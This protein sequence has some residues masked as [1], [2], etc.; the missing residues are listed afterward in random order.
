[1]KFV[2]NQK[3]L[4]VINSEDIGLF[5][6][7]FKKTQAHHSIAEG[8]G[9]HEA[10]VGVEAQFLLS[11]RNTQGNLCHGNLDIITVDITND[12]GQDC[13]EEVRIQDNKDGTYEISY[14]VWEVDEYS[15]VVKLNGEHVPGSPF[16]LDVKSQLKVRLPP[17]GSPGLPI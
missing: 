12:Q 5:V 2:E 11:T 17:L 16:A 10:V 14:L 13:A 1:M 9:I 8:K 15:V 6:V 4:H 7:A 3:L